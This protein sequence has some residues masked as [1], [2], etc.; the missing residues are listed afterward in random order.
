MKM[1]KKSELEISNGYMVKDDEIIPVSPLVV[2]ELEILDDLFQKAN[3][4]HAQ[5]AAKPA[6][7]LEG[8]E[9]MG[10]SSKVR[11]KAKTPHLDKQVKKSLKLLEELNSDSVAKQAEEMVNGF[12]LELIE[13]VK[14]DFIV[15]GS[16]SVNHIAKFGDYQFLKG[17]EK[18]SV[19][20]L[21]E[22][23]IIDIVV[24]CFFMCD[25][26]GVNVKKTILEVP[27]DF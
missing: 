2:S 21:E 4:L 17:I 9:K 24:A 16:A 26:I 22:D 3:Y 20:E 13:W 7:S 1:I 19:L 6:P 12:L 10:G 18:D 23:D 14:N 27:E 11:I 8:F 5:G 15:E 25:E